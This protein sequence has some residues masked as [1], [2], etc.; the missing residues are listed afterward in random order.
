MSRRVELAGLIL[1][2][3]LVLTVIGCEQTTAPS[4]SSAPTVA[5]SF[6][7]YKPPPPDG[8]P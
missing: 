3:A 5:P 6:E 2:S 1:V 4:N 8:Q 7:G